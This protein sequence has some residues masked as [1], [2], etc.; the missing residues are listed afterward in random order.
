[1]T[2]NPLE[3]T[4]R[5]EL[6]AFIRERRDEELDKV[7]VSVGVGEIL[8][9]VFDQMSRDFDPEAGPRE[10]VVVQWDIDGPDGRTHVWQLVARPEE[11]SAVE[12]APHAPQVTFRL[13]LVTF[14]KLVTGLVPGLKALA[15]GKLKLKGDLVLATSVEGWFRR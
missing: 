3:I 13:R 11:C 12:G 2:V 7:A 15:T 5:E 1:M 10:Q 14:L 8:A 9:R 6:A 4:S